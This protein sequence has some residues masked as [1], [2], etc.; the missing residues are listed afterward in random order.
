MRNLVAIGVKLTCP[1]DDEAINAAK[2]VADGINPAVMRW[3]QIRPP[4][5]RSKV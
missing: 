2:C 4:F 3:K 5:T 1:D